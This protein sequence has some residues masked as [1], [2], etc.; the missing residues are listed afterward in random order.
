MRKPPLDFDNELLEIFFWSLANFQFFIS[1]VL[2]FFFKTC[3]F[4]SFLK[5]LSIFRF[6]KSHGTSSIE[7]FF[8][9]S[10]RI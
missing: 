10:F 5:F 7:M 2:A 1:Q 8:K 4:F 6:L 9:F 3:I